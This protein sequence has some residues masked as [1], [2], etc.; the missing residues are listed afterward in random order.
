MRKLVFVSFLAVLA[1]PLAFAAGVAETEPTL[2]VSV[3][4][5]G[6]ELDQFRPVV[7][8]FEQ[9]E[10]VRV[11][12]LTYRAEDLAAVLPAQF[13]AGQTLA[14]VIFM[15]DWWIEENPQHA[16]DLSEV[17]NRH[18]A[19]IVPPPIEAE[20]RTVGVPFT[21]AAKPGFWYRQSFFEEHGLSE[22]GTWDEFTELLMSIGQIQGVQAPIATGNGVGWPISDITEHFLIAYG[23]AQLQ[24]DLIDGTVD[25]QSDQVR[26]VFQ[27]R[28]VPLLEA[29]AFSDPIEW[30]QAVELWWDGDYGLYFMGNWIT[31]MVDDAADLGVFQLPEATA[32]VTAP[33]TLFIPEYSDQQEL[34]LRFADFLLSEEGQRIRAEA[35]GK[36]IVRSDISADVYPEADQAVAAVVAGME[37]TVPDLD[38]SIGGDWQP[39]FWDQLKLL[40]VQPGE[41]DD[42]LRRLDE[43]R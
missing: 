24:H 42:V 4:W 23:G 7:E 15:W 3:P 43:A 34:A 32:I 5:S 11:R 6:E 18:E 39:T 41:L 10:N 40:W 21:M 25:W 19:S 33:D 9:Q 22:P 31:G 16:I 28:I 35:G 30:T 17:W 26:E 37:T 27:T 1:V 38:D 14:D 29:G 20:G 8:A 2:N 13:Q 12:Y 36:L